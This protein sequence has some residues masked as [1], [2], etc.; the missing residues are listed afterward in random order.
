MVTILKHRTTWY[1]VNWWCFMLRM[2]HK[3][4]NLSEIIDISSLGY[5]ATVVIYNILKFNVMGT[6][7]A[8]V[9][10]KERFLE[11]NISLKTHIQS[12][13]ISTLVVQNTVFN[14]SKQI[15]RHILTITKLLIALSLIKFWILLE[16][17]TDS[18]FKVHHIPWDYSSMKPR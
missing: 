14:Q 5:T 18:T 2:I 8:Q 9:A 10:L 11:A 4:S 16:Y 6:C 12:C 15:L 1:P 3:S 17:N 13:P 7:V